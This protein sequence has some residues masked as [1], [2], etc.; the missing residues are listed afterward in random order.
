MAPGFEGSRARVASG[1]MARKNF[2]RGGKRPFR[3]KQRKVPILNI[4][5][6]R[7]AR[8]HWREGKRPD[9]S[10]DLPSGFHPATN[11]GSYESFKFV[12]A[13][14]NTHIT[15]RKRTSQTDSNVW[16]AEIWGAPERVKQAIDAIYEYVINSNGRGEKKF[17][18]VGG[19]LGIRGGPKY[20]EELH[21]RLVRE[22]KRSK[23]CQNHSEEQLAAK[24]YS[25]SL[26][27]VSHNCD[28][29]STVALICIGENLQNL[30]IIFCLHSQVYQY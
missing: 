28:I 14:S 23:F 29:Q 6:D 3:G 10:Y 25:H 27:V 12:E 20:E 22:Q 16:V 5:S 26:V 15:L 4:D 9:G 30:I 13:A 1:L 18:N 21:K 7:E 11:I 2:N 17:A 19:E 8:Q 24:R